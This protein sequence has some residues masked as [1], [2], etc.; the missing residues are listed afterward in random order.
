[1]RDSATPNYNTLVNTLCPS[2]ATQRFVS[3]QFTLIYIL[4]RINFEA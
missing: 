2:D 4:F 1:M 3:E